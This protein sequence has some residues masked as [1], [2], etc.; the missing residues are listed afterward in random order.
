MKIELNI[1]KK[2]F[3]IILASVLLLGGLFITYAYGT[4]D[5]PVFGHSANEIDG[6]PNCNAGQAL[7]HSSSG[8]SCVSSSTSG[9]FTNVAI[10]DFNN[11]RDS[12]G[13][14]YTSANGQYTWNVPA[15][16]TKVKV[17][18][19]GGG[20]G[21]PYCTTGG[22]C[23]GGQSGAYGAGIYQITESAYQ[24]TVAR[25]GVSPATNPPYVRYSS[26][27]GNLIMA[28]GGYGLVSSLIPLPESN[29]QIRINGSAYGDAP[30]GGNKNTVPGG[31]AASSEEYKDFQGA[32]KA[33]GAP[34]RVIVY[35]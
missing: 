24:I 18:V 8:W 12:N 35:W 6:F 15:G 29:G 21:N 25:G 2:Y 13:N 20:G 5:P 23:P 19:W 22:F 27:F 33:V 4:N 28:E 34:G 11:A 7:T 30:N 31:G 1:S 26:S 3:F 16:V 17:E 10:F 32:S 14:T 9:G